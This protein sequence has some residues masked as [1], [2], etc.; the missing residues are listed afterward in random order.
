MQREGI[1]FGMYATMNGII[2][3]G[4]PQK[5]TNLCTV[6]PNSIALDVLN[7]TNLMEDWQIQGQHNQFYDKTPPISDFS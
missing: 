2:L 6:G 3:R 1:S 4:H 5:V 7:M